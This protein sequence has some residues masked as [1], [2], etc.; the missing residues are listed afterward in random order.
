MYIV[1]GFHIFNYVCLCFSSDGE[2]VDPTKKPKSESLNNKNTAPAPQQQKVA[3]ISRD[4]K[5]DS[6]SPVK[7]SPFTYG[8]LIVLG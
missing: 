5:R 6:C 3:K 7:G 1:C 8:E 4:N 2:S